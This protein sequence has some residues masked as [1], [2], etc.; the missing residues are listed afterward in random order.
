M[1]AVKIWNDTP[2]D[3]Q[4][5]QIADRLAAGEIWIIP[6]DSI[7][8]IMCDAFNSKAI[9]KVCRLK[10]INPEKN[11]LSIVCTDISMASEYARISDRTYTLMKDNTPGPFTFLCKSQSTLPK[12]FK[13]RKTVGIRIPDCVTAR[14]IAERLGHPLLTSSIEFEDEDYAR[15]PELIQ[16]AY[17]GKVDGIAVGDNG[18][19]TPT[20]IIDCTESS[21]FIVREG[22]GIFEPE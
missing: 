3:R 15:N 20:T 19:I 6:T 17:D 12:E 4:I 1:K 18:G 9:D 10:N 14:A 16:E 5:E 2:S 22:L 8:G 11:N 13:R 7:Y 21:P